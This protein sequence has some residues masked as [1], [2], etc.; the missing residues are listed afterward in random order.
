MQTS[1]LGVFRSEEP[2]HSFKN[3][4]YFF[5]YVLHELGTILILRPEFQGTTSSEQK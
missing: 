1:L 2:F 3:A 4:F 5:V